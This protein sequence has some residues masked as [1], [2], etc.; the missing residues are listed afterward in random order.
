MNITV[1]GINYAPELTGIAPYNTALCE[2]LQRQGHTVRMVTSFPYY[3]AW[4][5]SVADSGRFCR[6]DEVN[7][8]SVHRCWHYVPGRPGTLKRILH[9]ASFVASS[10]IRLLRLPRPDV[11]VV[12]SPPLLLGAAAWLLTRV[13]PAPVV[14]H[15][16]DMQPDAALGLGM[17]KPGLFMRMLYALE[18]FAYARSARVS[19]I[20]GDMLKAMAA[21]GV[22]VAKL[23]CFPNGVTLPETQPAAGAFRARHGLRADDFVAVYSGNLGVK[24]GLEILIEAA[25]RVAHPRMQLVICGDGAMRPRLEER[26][27]EQKLCNV[28]LLPLQDEAH[29]LEMLVDADVTLVT[30]Q[31][32]SGAFFFPSKLLRSL[33]LARPVLT[34]A[35]ESSEL[36]RAL[37]EGGFGVNVPPGHADELA[38]VLDELAVQP[39]RL[40]G[41]GVAGRRFVAQFEQGKVLREFTAHLTVLGAAAGTRE[42]AKCECEVAG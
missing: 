32:G 6:T 27:R 33:A 38:R 28:R 21:K 5:K 29:Y 4:K 3:P 23:I 26:I 12:V 34:V 9:E 11:F 15:V 8:V 10:L 17:L 19:A 30:Q 41:Y 37:T 25:A 14:F 16:Q 22:P 18:A 42:R 1:W 35:D 24:Q 20:S 36:A 39:E 7:G 13:K 31:A 2:H 40:Q